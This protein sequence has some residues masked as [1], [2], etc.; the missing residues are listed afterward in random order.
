MPKQKKF[1]CCQTGFS[2]AALI[3]V[4]TILVVITG[5]YLLLNKGGQGIFPNFF[6]S[7]IKTSPVVD[8]QI[9]DDRRQKA[10]EM[11]NREAERLSKQA[12]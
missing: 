9:T 8:G 5:A 4:I 2:R 1:L 3:I 7:E 12:E 10:T 11:L 6:T